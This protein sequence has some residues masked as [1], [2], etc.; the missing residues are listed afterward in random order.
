LVAVLDPRPESKATAKFYAS[1]KG[2]PHATRCRAYV[3]IRAAELRAAGLQ[4]VTARKTAKGPLS[5]K[6]AT[7]AKEQQ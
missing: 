3:R 2:N 4:N 1:Q 5:L 6:D 7:G